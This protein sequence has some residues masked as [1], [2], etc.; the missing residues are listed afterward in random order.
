MM[1]LI[2]ITIKIKIVQTESISHKS[3]DYSN[4]Q[5]IHKDKRRYGR[6]RELTSTLQHLAFRCSW[7]LLMILEASWI[8]FDDT[9]TN[10]YIY[11]YI[12]IWSYNLVYTFFS[13]FYRQKE[14]LVFCILQ[15]VNR[16]AWTRPGPRSHIRFRFYFFFFFSFFVFKA[17]VLLWALPTLHLISSMCWKAV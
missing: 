4:K 12:Y 7:L 15:L 17:L 14:K 10:I 6:E 8:R 5:T 11:I 2:I 1:F 3:Y 13:S 16:W 9:F